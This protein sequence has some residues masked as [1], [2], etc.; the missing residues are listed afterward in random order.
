MDSTSRYSLS[1]GFP[2][3]NNPNRNTQAMMLNKMTLRMPKRVRKNG[4]NKIKNVSD[5]CEMD[6]NRLGCCTPKESGYVVW[7]S[8]RNGP[9]NA[10]VI[11]NAA[12]NR[13]ENTKNRAVFLFLS[14]TKASNP[15][16]DISV[17]LRV[18][19]RNGGDGGTVSAYPARNKPAPADT[20]N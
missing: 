10:L 4:I 13:S 17:F 19:S 11:C 3:P 20:Y 6:S 1:A 7:K 2:S 15:R 16:E 14:N 8:F 9:P 5:S 12:P 18:S